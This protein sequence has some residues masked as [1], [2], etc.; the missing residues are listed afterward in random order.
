N[1]IISKT[2]IVNF[3]YEMLLIC[4]TTTS[5]VPSSCFFSRRALAVGVFSALPTAPIISSS[6][7]KVV[8]SVTVMFLVSFLLSMITSFLRT[9]PAEGY[10]HGKDHQT[11]SGHFRGFPG[12]EYKKDALGQRCPLTHLPDPPVIDFQSPAYLEGPV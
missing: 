10:N 3:S 12:L 1:A 6:S 8:S 2:Y 4:L 11:A 7:L 5:T 9:L